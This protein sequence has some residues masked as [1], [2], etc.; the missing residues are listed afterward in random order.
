MFKNFIWGSLA[1]LFSSLVP[2]RTVSGEGYLYLSEWLQA[3]ENNASSGSFW[4]AA[5]VVLLTLW[6]QYWLA[7][8]EKRVFV[9][10]TVAFTLSF[11]LAWLIYP[12]SKAVQGTQLTYH[13]AFVSTWA[14]SI[15]FFILLLHYKGFV[16]RFFLAFS[17]VT[18]CIAAYRLLFFA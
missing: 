18:M 14:N 3:I 10:L 1:M 4:I 16:L 15:S 7:K 2:A 17:T 12:H 13:F 6:S 11:C 5:L 8:H 9:L